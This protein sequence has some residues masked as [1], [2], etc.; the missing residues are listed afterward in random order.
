MRV[1]AVVH[2]DDADTGV[3]AEAVASRGAALEKWIPAAHGPP[4]AD[5]YDAAM[6]FGGA[7]HVDQEDEN[8]WL[9]PEKAWL[10][11]L[12]VRGTPVLGVCLGA[13][14]LAEAAGAG[15]GP[16]AA[17]EIGWYDVEVTDEGSSDPLLGPFTPRF[18]AF[19]W[20]SYE[21]PLPPAGVPLARNANCLQA[22]RVDPAAWG[23]QFHAEVTR[24]SIESWL[25]DYGS[26]AEAV[27]AGVDPKRLT[28]DTE[29]WIEGWNE[30]G[31]AL[32]LRFLD[33]ADRRRVTG[34]ATASST[35]A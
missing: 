32:C 12:L 33:E 15:P 30:A 7:M 9:R 3:F 4:G 34:P 25:G 17:P 1:L 8:P 2:Q 26:E 21:F 11:E 6:V 13:Q 19:Q 29:H 5:A 10:R 28:A 27:R 18:T 16:S 20:H 14:L 24:D 22:Y 35:P 23:I 31:R